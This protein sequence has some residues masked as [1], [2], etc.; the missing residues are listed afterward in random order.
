MKTQCRFSR[1]G[2]PRVLPAAM[3]CH[4][5][6]AGGPRDLALPLS[7]QE[8]LLGRSQPGCPTPASGFFL[9]SF[10]RTVEWRSKICFSVLPD[11]NSAS[12]SLCRDSLREHIQ[13]AHLVTVEG[14]CRQVY[15]CR[16]GCRGPECVTC[17]LVCLHT[18][19]VPTHTKSRVRFLGRGD[20]SSVL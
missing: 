18:A 19:P 20:F 17:H 11:G 14:I 9:P 8:F 15:S 7:M 10:P 13:D 12:P 5:C 1:A 16:W 2:L 6:P 3:S 4:G